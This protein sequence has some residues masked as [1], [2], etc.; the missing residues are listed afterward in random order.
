MAFD[1]TPT[2]DGPLAA[3]DSG[4]PNL[5][6]SSYLQFGTAASRPAQGN[7]GVLFYAT[8]TDVLSYDDG[9]AW[10]TVLFVI[11]AAAGTGSLRTIGTG[12][13]Q[14]AAGNHPHQTITVASTRTAGAG[15]GTQSIV[16]GFPP[17]GAI[18]IATDA[19]EQAGQPILSIGFMDDNS[20]EDA[21]SLIETAGDSEVRDNAANFLHMQD[22]SDSMDAVA[23]ING[24]NIDIT[25]T[26]GGAGLTVAF[27]V[28]IFGT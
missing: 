15:S 27:F 24:N 3:L 9:A 7:K 18:I 28:L 2:Y 4:T 20:D 13:L 21:I 8:D 25:W 11:D 10:Q 1:N 16:A 26:K 6:N 19:T 5:M 22:G 14:A 12:A 23:A 17:W